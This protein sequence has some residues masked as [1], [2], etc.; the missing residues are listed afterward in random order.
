VS[1]WSD[2]DRR[3]LAISPHPQWSTAN[4]IL[5]HKSTHSKY[6]I[7]MRLILSLIPGILSDLRRNYHDDWLIEVILIIYYIVQ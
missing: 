5:S 3:I 4:E 6:I 1:H 7:Q 2:L